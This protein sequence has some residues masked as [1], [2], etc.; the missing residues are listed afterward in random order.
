MMEFEGRNAVEQQFN[1]VD[2]QD[3]GQVP[4]QA[5]RPRVYKEVNV[6]T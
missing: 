3:S 1:D 5:S 4:V 6:L 2:R